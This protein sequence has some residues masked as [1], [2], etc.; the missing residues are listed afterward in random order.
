MGDPTVWAPPQ[1]PVVDTT[2]PPR[3]TGALVLMWGGIALMIIG[4]VGLVGDW[5][6]RNYEMTRL[7]SAIE[8]SEAAMTHVKDEVVAVNLPQDPT[9]AQIAQA[10]Q[11]IERIAA[12]GQQDVRAAG[13]D[14]GGVSFLPWHSEMVQAQSAYL[15]HNG[16]WVAYLGAGSQDARTLF[17]NDNAI[18]PTWVAAERNVRA[19]VPPLAWPTISSRVDAIFSDDEP[20]DQQDQPQDGNQITT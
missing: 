15:A 8:Q 20:T 14:V 17:G 18:D 13:A 12:Q 16:A 4:F 2:P 6:A 5:A 9:P 11:Q 1:G 7:L 10:S 19:A 3:K